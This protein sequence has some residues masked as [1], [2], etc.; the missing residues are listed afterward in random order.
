MYIIIKDKRC[1]SHF[2]NDIDT[3]EVDLP[4]AKNNELVK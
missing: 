2:Q 1:H 3:K 4:D